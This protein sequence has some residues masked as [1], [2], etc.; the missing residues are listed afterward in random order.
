MAP[1]TTTE[2][3]YAY[4]AAGAL[5]AE[6]GPAE[7]ESD[8]EYFMADR[9]GSV[10]MKGSQRYHYYPYDQ[11]IGGATTNDTPKFGTYT[12]DVS[13]LDY[14]MNRFY[15]NEWG[16]VTSPD[17][18]QASG[19]PADP[20]SWNR[21]AYVGGNPVNYNDPPGLQRWCLGD[22]VMVWSGCYGGDIPKDVVEAEEVSS[23]RGG[24]GT[25]AKIDKHTNDAL[26]SKLAD[27]GQDAC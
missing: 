7:M 11:E 12:R 1:A 8:A 21:Y 24:G 26:L 9:L 25:V 18:Y 23:E 22:P 13:G 15:K 20:G 19:G 10:V 6:Y 16:R 3:R 17:S 14:A 4:N 5:A 2:T 27:L